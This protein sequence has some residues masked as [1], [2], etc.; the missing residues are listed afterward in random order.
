[1]TDR[2]PVA[3]DPDIAYGEQEILLDFVRNRNLLLAQEN[4]NLRQRLAELKG[5]LDQEGGEQP[6]TKRIRRGA[7][8]REA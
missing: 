5:M 7:A 6:R 3:I 8:S 2:Q 4:K 1:M